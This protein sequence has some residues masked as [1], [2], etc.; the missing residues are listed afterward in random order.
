MFRAHESQRNV[1]AMF[2]A[3]ARELFRPQPAYNYYQPEWTS[4]F[5]SPGYGPQRL[6]GAFE[7]LDYLFGHHVA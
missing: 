2:D 3:R 4:F 1:L 7:K 6:L 5:Y